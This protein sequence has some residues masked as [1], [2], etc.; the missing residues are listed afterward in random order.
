LPTFRAPAGTTTGSQ[1][2]TRR[3]SQ[4]AHLLGVPASEAIPIPESSRHTSPLTR[5]PLGVT[6]QRGSERAVDPFGVPDSERDH[7]QRL[8]RARPRVLQDQRDRLFHL[9]GHRDLLAGFRALR[10]HHVAQAV[11]PQHAG[12]RGQRA[13][14][15]VGVG[16][17][18]SGSSRLR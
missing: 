4:V 2:R 14:V 1:G 18:T 3:P 12:E 13:A 17:A 7:P 11:I 6:G 5:R 15:D 16:N 10:D 9:G 8:S